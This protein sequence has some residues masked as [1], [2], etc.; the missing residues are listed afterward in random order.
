MELRQKEMALDARN[1]ELRRQEEIKL[2]EIEAARL[3]EA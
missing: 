3:K 1:I 2:A